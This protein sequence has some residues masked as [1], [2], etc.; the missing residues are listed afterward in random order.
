MVKVRVTVTVTNLS[1]P[2]P[3]SNPP[4]QVYLLDTTVPSAFGFFKHVVSQ[5]F[6][7][8]PLVSLIQVLVHRR[9]GGAGGAAGAVAPHFFPN[10]MLKQ[11]RFKT[12]V[13]FPREAYKMYFY[14][15]PPPLVI[16]L[17]RPCTVTSHAVNVL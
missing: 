2:N 3:D 5:M 17:R 7:D 12:L 1:Y 15:K 6:P 8:S 14:L 16:P 11:L 9:D 4:S 10:V 13:Q